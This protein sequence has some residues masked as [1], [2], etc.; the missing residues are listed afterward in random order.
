MEESIS[1]MSH[2]L[3]DSQEQ[4]RTRIGREL[5]DDINQRLAMLAIEL[6]QLKDD[7]SEVQRRAEELRKQTI[8]LS[9]DVQSLS[10]ELHSS[11]LECLGVTSGIRSW[12]KEFGERQGLEINFKADVLSPIPLEIGVTLF[13]ILQ[14]ALHNAVKHSGVKLIDVQLSERSNDVQLMIVD[15]GKG[16]AVEAA[17]QGRGLGLATME[18]RARLVKG[19]VSFESRP[20]S[21]TKVYVRV[22]LDLGQAPTGKQYS[23]PISG[24][25]TLR[26]VGA[27]PSEQ[28]FPNNGI[29]GHEPLNAPRRF[30]ERRAHTSRSEL[31]PENNSTRFPRRMSW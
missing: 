6:Q 23:R 13:R 29:R 15:A 28:P 18:E 7:P 8:E 1:S 31:R 17:K 2:K 20:M 5:N 9:N 21:G 24:R 3:I 22:P 10:H 26:C 14:E 27:S 30:V 12:C 25:N 4:E 11:K 19:T 16:F